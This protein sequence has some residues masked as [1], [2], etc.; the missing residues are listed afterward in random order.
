MPDLTFEK[1]ACADG[2]QVIAGID[3]AGRGPWA[4]PVVAGA[5]VFKPDSIPAALRRDLDD[6]KKLKPV[7]RERLFEG[8]HLVARIGVGVAEVSEI[9]DINILQA[10]LLA[11]GRAVDDLGGPA[12]DFALVDG[13]KAPA[14]ACLVRTVVKGD[15]LSLSIA[16]AS[17]IAKVTRDRIMMDLDRRYPGYGWARNAG[18]GTPEHQTALARLGI[19]PAHRRSYAPIRKI[20]SPE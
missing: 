8:L 17:I 18:Y 15:G 9:D 6:S 16:A 13:N 20:L 2:H 4:G 1:E 7:D 11:M 10:T 3:E 19:T 12:P 14:L 5:V